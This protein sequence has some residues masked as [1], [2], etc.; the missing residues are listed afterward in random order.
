MW[1][2]RKEKKGQPGIA[3]VDAGGHGLGQPLVDIADRGIRHSAAEGRALDRQLPALALVLVLAVVLAV[4]AAEELRLEVHVHVLG[5]LARGR[6]LYRVRVGVV[7][8]VHARDRHVLHAVAQVLRF[9]PVGLGCENVV[10]VF[11]S[12]FL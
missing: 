4:A 9:R 8:L 6:V 12:I 11:C 5:G 10:R 2:K 3:L 1:K 7:D